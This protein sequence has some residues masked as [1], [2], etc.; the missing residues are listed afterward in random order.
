MMHCFVLGACVFTHCA[1]TT[2]MSKQQDTF[3]YILVYSESVLRYRDCLILLQNCRSFVEKKNRPLQC[4][5]RCPPKGVGVLY[6]VCARCMYWGYSV[7]LP[8]DFVGQCMCFFF[9]VVQCKI[10]KN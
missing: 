5:Y 10:V 3:R 9:D 2:P 7:D 4:F 1:P 6:A 8:T